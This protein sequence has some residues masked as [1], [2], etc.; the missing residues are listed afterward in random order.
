LTPE[1]R[2][3]RK[4]NKGN[5]RA[6]IADNCNR[7]I[8][9]FSLCGRKTLDKIYSIPSSKSLGF[10]RRSTPER[11]PRQAGSGAGTQNGNVPRR[12]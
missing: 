7:S 2:Q 12:S 10:L 11:F 5:F 9:C 3:R 6:T 4:T 8:H 1:N